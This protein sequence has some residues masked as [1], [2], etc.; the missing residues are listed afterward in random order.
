MD[1]KEIKQ[2]ESNIETIMA[3]IK[4]FEKISVHLHIMYSLVAQQLLRTLFEIE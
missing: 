2:D 4:F 1:A 3:S